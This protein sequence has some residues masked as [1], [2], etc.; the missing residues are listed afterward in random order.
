MINNVFIDSILSFLG[1]FLAVFGP[2]A[3][4]ILLGYFS[5][6]TGTVLA[7]SLGNKKKISIRLPI[8]LFIMGLSVAFVAN[9]FPSSLQLFLAKYYNP[10]AKISGAFIFFFGFFFLEI[11]SVKLTFNKANSRFENFRVGASVLLLGVAFGIAWTHCLTPILTKIIGPMIKNPALSGRGLFLLWMYALGLAVPL[12]SSALFIK[13]VL[14]KYKVFNSYSR[15]IK[16]F[17]GLFLASFGVALFI[18]PWWIYLSQI[19]IN[20]THTGW[21]NQLE[22]LLIELLK[23][24]V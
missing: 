14:N 9:F 8:L 3:W 1:G 20:W 23:K 16:I 10:S 12:L 4:L 13:T 15:E 7:G 22:T 11:S 17:N 6:T 19:L 24:S 2:C 21:K 18:K 5:F